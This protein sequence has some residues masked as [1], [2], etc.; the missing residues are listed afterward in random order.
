MI[1]NIVFD[2]GQVLIR[3]NASSIAEQYT[4]S[5]ED[6][7]L[8]LQEVFHSTEWISTDRGTLTPKEA[9]EICKQRI[10]ERL[11]PSVDK[12]FCSWHNELI[13]IP[14]MEN[15]VKN[16]KENYYK[17][18]LLSNT[19]SDFYQFKDRIPALK[20]F[21]DLFISADWQIIKPDL[22]IYEKFCDHFALLPSECFFIDDNPANI[23]AAKYM[24][25]NGTIFKNNFSELVKAI[26]TFD[27]QI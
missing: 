2:M 17:I 14:E 26:K 15:L 18:Y 10:P 4:Q 27:I 12:C 3:F 19:S 9:A 24:G 11:Y 25:W 1:K 21:D 23:E 6:K 13:L 22:R 8:L 5:A 20:Y 7:E 16:L